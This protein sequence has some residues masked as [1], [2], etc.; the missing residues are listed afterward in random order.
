MQIGDITGTVEDI[1]MRVTRIRPFS[2]ALIVVPNGEISRIANYNRGFSRA[3]VEVG[4]A[5]EADIDQA[6]SVLE[7][8]AEKYHRE[9]PRRILEPA[10]IHRIVRLDSSRVVLRLV[11]KVAPQ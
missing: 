2:G 7:E 6:I 9:H 3:I 11:L 8:V 5:Y 4:I 10:T 1:G